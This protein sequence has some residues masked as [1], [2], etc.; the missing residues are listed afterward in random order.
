MA[1]IR[2]LLAATFLSILFAPAA[3]AGPE[4]E[5]DLATADRCDYLDQAICLCQFPHDWLTTGSG[6]ARRLNLH[7]DSMPRNALGK[8]VDPEAYNRN[9]GFSPGQLIATKVPG[10]DTPE[11]FRKTR[12]V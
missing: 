7:P 10:L 3:L 12:A 8:G 6:D 1:Q 4:D 2:A 9:D 5:V 11:A